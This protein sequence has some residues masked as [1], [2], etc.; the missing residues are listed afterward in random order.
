MTTIAVTLLASA[1]FVTPLQEQGPSPAEKAA[2]EKV[3]FLVGKWQGKGWVMEPSGAKADYTGTETVQ[4]KLS[5]KALLVEGEFKDGEGKVR[6][7]TLAIITYDT[8]TSKYQFR[9]Y[10][11]N[12]PEAV[13]DLILTEDGFTWELKPNNTTKVRFNMT[14]KAKQEWIETGEVLIEGRPPMKFM[15]MNLKKVG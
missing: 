2:I 11:F 13:H 4:M 7:Q 14:G 8:K 10:L 3:G 12:Q 1:A 15:E 5:G 9:T 6:H